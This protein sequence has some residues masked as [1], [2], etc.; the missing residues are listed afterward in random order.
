MQRG[1]GKPVACGEGLA[2]GGFPD[3]SKVL[4]P[5]GGF[6]G[7]AILGVSPKSNCR[8]VFWNWR[9]SP[10]ERLHQEVKNEQSTDNLKSSTDERR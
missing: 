4:N 5:K 9:G 10:H 1:L 7:S 6:R 3:I 2:V 8:P